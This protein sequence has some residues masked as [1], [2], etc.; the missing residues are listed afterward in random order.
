MKNKKRTIK[1]PKR[2]LT[3]LLAVIGGLFIAFFI[4]A[5]IV[6]YTSLTKHMYEP[7]Q[8]ENVTYDLSKA[9]FIDGEDFK[10]FGLDLVCTEFD[11]NGKV[12]FSITTYKLED[13]EINVESIT[14]RICMTA[15]YLDYIEY[16]SANSNHKLADSKSTA[17]SSSNIYTY[18]L[19]SREFPA[20]VDA[21]PFDIKVKEPVAYVYLQYVVNTG[22]TKKTKTYVLQYDYE[23][24]NVQIGGISK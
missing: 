20:K 16:S 6:S 8:T 18:S 19:N 23:D 24:F 14:I 9:E 15:D 11:V 4:T 22:T 17:T 1:G 12:K 2:N 5:T 3:T 7:F 21:F 10:D 13:Q